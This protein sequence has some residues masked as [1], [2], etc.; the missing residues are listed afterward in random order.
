[1]FKWFRRNYPEE[2]LQSGA[3]K[4]TRSK[5]EREKDFRFEEIVASANPVNWEVKTKYRKFPIF[6]QDGSGSCVAQTQ[7]KEMGVMRWLQDKEYIHF[8]ATDIYQQRKNKPQS[9]MWATDARDIA[10]KGG[11]TLEILTKS[12]GMGDRAMD[13][14]VIEP[15]KKEVGAVFAVPNY[16]SLPIGDID[17]VASVIQT[18]GKAVM[19]WFYFA[20]D[21]WTDT[22]KILHLDQPMSGGTTVRHS[23]AAVDFTLINGVKYLVIEDSWGTNAGIGGQRLISEDFFKARNFYSGYLVNFR[24]EDSVQPQK[25]KHRFLTLLKYSPTFTVVEEV[26]ALQD[27]LKYE[28]L[29]PLN[30]ASTGYYGSITAKAV[31]A[32]QLK[33]KV[34]SEATLIRL[35]GRSLGPL[36]RKKLNELYNK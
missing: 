7:A 36:T 24:Y 5:K 2:V 8:S 9:G 19:V 17:T 13:N 25:P 1:M 31:L 6:N 35:G 22:P 18:T 21:E 32:F 30:I 34:A 14:T 26:K 20:R 15:Y 16:V 27:I 12:Q 28:G 3:V 4:D 10:R 29:F 11:A 23:I 33:Y